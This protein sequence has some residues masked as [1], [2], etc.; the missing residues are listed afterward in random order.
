ML[1]ESVCA[2]LV[3]VISCY[4]SHGNPPEGA[5]RETIV[6]CTKPRRN[7][8]ANSGITVFA[9]H[10]LGGVSC[11][12]L[13]CQIGAIIRSN[14]IALALKLRNFCLVPLSAF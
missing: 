4:S 2:I 3:S 7:A 10:D 1:A 12:C 8:A 5:N 11:G 14:W 9:R 6:S 13:A